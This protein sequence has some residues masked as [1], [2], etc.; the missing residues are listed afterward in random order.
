MH[1]HN[2]YSLTVDTHQIVSYKLNTD[3]NSAKLCGNKNL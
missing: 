1:A 3:K 2:H